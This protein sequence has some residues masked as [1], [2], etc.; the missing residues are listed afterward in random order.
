[1]IYYSKECTICNKQYE[2]TA[3]QK[4]CSACKAVARSRYNTKLGNTTYV[5]KE[6]KECSD[7]GNIYTPTSNRQKYCNDCR[8]RRLTQ[9]NAKAYEKRYQP[10]GYNQVGE[11]N[12]NWV[13]GTS[14]GR[15]AR[16]WA[17]KVYKRK[18][19]CERCGSTDNIHV[20]HK[21]RDRDDNSDENLE[22]L[23]QSCHMKEHGKHS[24]KV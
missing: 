6:P 12:N 8:G 4:Y 17:F 1:M 10:K 19:I 23:C 21:N 9:G 24:H 14:D 5:N 7:C 3:R 15:N 16:Y 13:G 18:P 20:H 11:S 22:I 2:G